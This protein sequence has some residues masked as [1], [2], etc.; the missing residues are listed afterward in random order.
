MKNISPL[1]VI[2]IFVF[3]VAL[4]QLTKF[5]FEGKSYFEGFFIYIFSTQNTGSAFGLFASF[6]FYSQVIAVVSIAILAGLFYLNTSYFDKS[7]YHKTA[8]VLLISSIMGNLIDRLLFGYVRDFIGVQWFSI[9]NI[10]DIYLTFGVAILILI[11]ISEG[12]VLKR[13]NS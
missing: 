4:D 5:Y 9:F 6:P 8:F 11:E 12:K 10:A 13:Q 2:A 1:R 7:L 3:L